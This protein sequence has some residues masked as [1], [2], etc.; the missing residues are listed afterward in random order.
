MDQ[1]AIALWAADCAERVLPYFEKECPIDN[2]PRLAIAAARAWA[3][4]EIK[5]GVARKAAFASH[6]A[7]RKARGSAAVAAARS[8]GHAAATAH[9]AA[10][11]L[12]SESYALKA[13]ATLDPAAVKAE[14]D[15][16]NTSH[17]KNS[18]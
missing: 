1:Q 16:Q 12:H 5:V 17:P 10:H 4:G 3:R 2:R 9:V 6:A 11:A 15:W 7:A 14:R 18:K 13:L 8:A